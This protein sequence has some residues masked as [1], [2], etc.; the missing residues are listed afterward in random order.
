MFKVEKLPNK[1][2]MAAT[3]T[4]WLGAFGL[5]ACGGENDTP[6][7][8]AVGVNCPPG[9]KPLVGQPHQV[10]TDDNPRFWVSCQGGD[11]FV[12]PDN[13]DWIEPFP[14]GLLDWK[15]PTSAYEEFISID[16]IPDS[17]ENSGAVTVS[18]SHRQLDQIVLRG[19]AAVNSIKVVERA[20]DLSGLQQEGS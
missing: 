20:P 6:S 17:D 1:A 15:L 11:R 14:A 5:A 8:L 10:K 12:S 16:Y 18:E 2:T 3:A 13:A 9:T 7:L 4:L 19:V